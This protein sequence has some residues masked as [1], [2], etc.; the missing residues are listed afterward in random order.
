MI[1]SMIVSNSVII[2]QVLTILRQLFCR[3]AANFGT[4]WS[5]TTDLDVAYSKCDY[6]LNW[7]K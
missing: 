3:R 5:S 7:N 1:V 6:S 2:Y 4:R